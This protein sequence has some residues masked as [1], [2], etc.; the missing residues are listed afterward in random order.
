MITRIEKAMIARLQAGLGKLVKSVGSYGGELSDSD[1]R[2]IVRQVPAVW[3]HFA[4]IQDT[5]AVDTARRQYKTTALFSV[6]LACRNVRS[7]QSTRYGGPHKLEIGS[8]QLVYAVRRILTGQDLTEQDHDLKIDYLYPKRVRNLRTDKTESGAIAVYACE[9]QT[10]WYESV[11]E[12]QR[13]PEP[14]VIQPG[15]P[16]NEGTEP[17]PADPNNPD[18]IFIDYGASIS[19]PYPPFEGAQVDLYQ[20]GNPDPSM[21]FNIPLEQANEDD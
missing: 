5:K 16:G 2:N 6:I 19:E 7:E 4:G 14:E 18:N 11:L 10:F 12:N 17:V 21:S 9:F 13:F 1:I 8:N 20:D 15:Q 3:V